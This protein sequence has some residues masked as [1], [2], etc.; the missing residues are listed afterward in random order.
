MDTLRALNES[1]GEDLEDHPGS[2]V[3]RDEV[4]HQSGDDVAGVE[5]GLQIAGDGA[6]QRTGEHR[7]HDDHWNE[8]PTRP[9]FRQDQSGDG[10]GDCTDCHL[11]L[12]TDIPEPGGERNR[13]RQRGGQKDSGGDDRLADVEG[14]A[15]RSGVNGPGNVDGTG[16]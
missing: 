6:K 16:T 7:G 8:E 14:V 4:E 12:A 3:Q 10:R 9:G 5:A 2:G 1:L 13:C 15:D 11:P